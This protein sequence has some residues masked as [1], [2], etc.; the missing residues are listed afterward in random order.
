MTGIGHEQVETILRLEVGDGLPALR[1]QDRSFVHRPAAGR[2][3]PMM[4]GPQ[5][6]GCT[7]PAPP[8]SRPEAT[9]DGARDDQDGE[10][11][12]SPSSMRPAHMLTCSHAH[13]V[14]V[15]R[16]TLHSAPWVLLPR[17]HGTASAQLHS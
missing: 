9:V 16:C 17:T 4:P 6:V 12:R 13:M 5:S 10:A 3:Q 2:T 15:V 11:V 14:V 7:T 8:V 1:N